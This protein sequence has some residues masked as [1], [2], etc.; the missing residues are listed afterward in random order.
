MQS[1]V[2]E[3]KKLRHAGLKV[4]VPRLKILDIL[5]NSAN[6]EQRHL[7]ADDIYRQLLDSGEEKVGLATVYRSLMQFEH[8]GLVA[9]R[10]FE[11][12]NALFELDDGEHHDHICCV[13]CGNV[14]EFMD[15]IIEQRQEKIAQEKG[16]TLEGHSLFMYGI[17][18]SCD[19][20]NKESHKKNHKSK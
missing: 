7:S 12:N 16:Y 19:S 14:T 5:T 8:A 1:S 2:S 17:C 15:E 18:S 3:E 20:E 13:I 11:G 6:S 9:R 4:T 10:N